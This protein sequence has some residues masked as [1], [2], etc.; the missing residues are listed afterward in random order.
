MSWWGSSALRSA[1]GFR[2]RSARL[3]TLDQ[4]NFSLPGLVLSCLGAVMLLM[5]VNF[6]RRIGEHGRIVIEEKH[7]SNGIYGHIRD[8]GLQ[9]FGAQPPCIRLRSPRGAPPYRLRYGMRVA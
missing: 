1:A 5:L 9:D 4:N 6:M 7:F 8:T 2:V 3:P